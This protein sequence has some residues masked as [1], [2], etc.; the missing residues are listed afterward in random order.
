[1]TFISLT[2]KTKEIPKNTIAFGINIDSQIDTLEKYF[3][4]I[5]VS[6]TLLLYPKSDFI[7]QSEYVAKK[8]VLKL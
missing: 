4:K 7:K 8:D 3:N 1:M 5:E 2:N 6:K